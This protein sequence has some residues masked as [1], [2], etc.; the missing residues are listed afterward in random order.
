MIIFAGSV[1][2]AVERSGRS[3][4]GRQR[5]HSHNVPPPYSRGD[6]GQLVKGYNPSSVNLSPITSG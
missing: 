1:I 3:C 4:A 6:K 5:V 2:V